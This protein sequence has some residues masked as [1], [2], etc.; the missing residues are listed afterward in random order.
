MYLS[1]KHNIPLAKEA[2]G[3]YYTGFAPGRLKSIGM[4]KHI[5]VIEGAINY[6]HSSSR[7]YKHLKVSTML[8]H[9]SSFLSL[10]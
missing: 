4:S 1:E 7:L 2:T 5:N 9:P 10:G 8:C 6:S 3:E